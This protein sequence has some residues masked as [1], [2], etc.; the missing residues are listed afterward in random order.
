MRR[1]DA[2]TMARVV[3]NKRTLAC[4][5]N[6]AHFVHLHW[7]GNRAPGAIFDGAV[8][9]SALGQGIG[10][11]LSCALG[12]VLDWRQTMSNLG[13]FSITA[14]RSGAADTSHFDMR[15]EFQRPAYEGFLGKCA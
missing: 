9:S 3:V 4:S 13:I 15:L 8:D 5:R 12:A 1:S 2:G 10:T 7:V 6:L 11:Q 14:E